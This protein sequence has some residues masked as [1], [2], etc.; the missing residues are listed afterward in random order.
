M[1]H[2]TSER[3]KGGQAVAFSGIEWHRVASNLLD[4]LSGE[5]IKVGCAKGRR[6]A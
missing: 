5:E 2:P 6:S 1:G 4:H 3:L